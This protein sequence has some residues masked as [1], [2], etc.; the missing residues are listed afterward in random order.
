MQESIDM[1]SI[2]A[3][4]KIDKKEYKKYPSLLELCSYLFQYE[5]KNLHNSMNDVVICLRCF[6]KMRF[7]EDIY[8]KNIIIKEMIDILK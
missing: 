1:C 6:Y 4:T 8:D 3:F 2:K 5:P 7:N